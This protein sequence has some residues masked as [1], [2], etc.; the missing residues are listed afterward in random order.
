MERCTKYIEFC[1]ENF[2]TFS[3]ELA[4][5]IISASAEFENVAKD[6]CNLIDSNSS[7]G[8][9]TEIYPVL[10]SEF[11][12]FCEVEV[13][14]PRYKINF[15]P[16]DQWTSNQRPDWWS[17]G[18]NKIKHSRDA[19]FDKA[20]LKNAI[21]SMGG[22]FTGILYYHQK[23]SGGIEVDYSRSPSLFDIQEQPE[24]MSGGG[25]SLSYSLPL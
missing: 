12:K 8:K 24:K 16:W 2:E 9:I 25:I 4:K 6:L 19:S 17:Q 18:Y 3:I 15:K 7:P 13:V 1:P 14:L 11:P 5:I 10:I 23:K 21:F 20:N 22:L